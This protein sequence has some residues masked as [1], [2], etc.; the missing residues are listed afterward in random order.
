MIFRRKKCIGFD[1]KY[2]AY[3]AVKLDLEQWKERKGRK[4][5]GKKRNLPLH[6]CPKWREFFNRP[7]VFFIFFISIYVNSIRKLGEQYFLLLP[8]VIFSPFFFFFS[9]SG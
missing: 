6:G 1:S 4:R 8:R 9:L 3:K 2:Q 5:E 7:S